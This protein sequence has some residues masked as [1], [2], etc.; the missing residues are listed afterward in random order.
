MIFDAEHAGYLAGSLA[1]LMSKSNVV[2]SVAGWEIPPVMA[3]VE[4]YRTGAQCANPAVNVI[5]TYT[6]N[7][8][9]PEV[10]ALAA[11]AMIAQGADVIFGV[12]GSMGVGAVV[13][14]TQSGAWGIGVDV[15]FYYSVYVSGTA[16][17]PGSDKLLS[18]AL[19]RV[20]NA[21]FGTIADTISGTFT[22]G[23]VLYDLSNGGVGLAPFHEA[24][25]SVSESVRGALG[26]VEQ[27]LINKIIDPNG[28]CPS[29]RYLPAVVKQ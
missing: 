9:D 5:I 7:F 2:G 10:G 28:P 20:D 22:A 29:Y 6:G 4:P 15:D 24:D 23:T 16:T 27:G 13:S 11:Q 18:S 21:V 26:R 19:K 17:L 12:G 3:F 14:A 8:D 25:A 1:G